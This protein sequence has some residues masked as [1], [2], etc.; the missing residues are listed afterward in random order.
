MNQSCQKWL[1]WRVKLWT[2]RKLYGTVVLLCNSEKKRH[3]V[4]WS[5]PVVGS[6]H[7]DPSCWIFGTWTDWGSLGLLQEVKKAQDSMRD[8]SWPAAWQA[9]CCQGDDLYNECPF[10]SGRHFPS[11]HGL[12]E[13]KP[14]LIRG[15]AC[16]GGPLV[17]SHCI[18]GSLALTLC[19]GKEIQSTGR[20]WGIK[21][22][23]PVHKR[24]L[25]DASV[26]LQVYL[27]EEAARYR[28]R[29][30]TY[31]LLQ[32]SSCQ[33]WNSALILHNVRTRIYP[34]YTHVKVC[35]WCK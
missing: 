26:V 21:P 3:L 17:G 25:L 22:C 30:G 1:E 32:T 29:K 8:Q 11:G 16:P 33:I 15:W 27:S 5:V 10:C 19:S 13:K 9:S 14:M 18:V 28:T 12:M 20:Y 24:F 34:L 7:L 35:W 23:S 31:T 4:S 2:A 6:L